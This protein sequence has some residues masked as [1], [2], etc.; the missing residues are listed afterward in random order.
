MSPQRRASDHWSWTAG[1]FLLILAAIGLA[2]FKVWTEW[3]V[4][5]LAA[6]GGVLVKGESVV[7]LARVFRKTPEPPTP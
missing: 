4:I 3:P 1:G 2:A 7:S 5:A 6:L